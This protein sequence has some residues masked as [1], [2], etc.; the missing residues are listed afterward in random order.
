MGVA[1]WAGPIDDGWGWVRVDDPAHPDAIARS[2]TGAVLR[3]PPAEGPWRPESIPSID[4]VAL[5]G[6]VAAEAIEVTGA[7]SWHDAGRRGAG[8]RVAV[9]DL[10]WFVGDSVPGDVGAFE[11]RDCFVSTTCEASFDVERPSL[12]GEQGAHGWACAEVIRD[13]APDA[14][15]VLV[16]VNSFTALENAVDWAIRDGVDL[17][18]LSMSY[19]NDSFYDGRG[20]HAPLMTALERAGV[21]LVTSAGNNAAQHVAFT[22]DDADGDGLD[23]GDGDGGRWVEWARGAEA[24]VYVNWDQHEA[25]GRTDLG[26]RLV[27]ERGWIVAEADRPQEA[28]DPECAPVERLR[29]TLAEGGRLRVE[30]FAARGPTS[31]LRVDLLTRQGDLEVPDPH[32]SVTDPAAHPF[33]LAVGAARA[34]AYAEGVPQPYSAWGPSHGGA[35]KPDLVG[36]DGLSTATFGPVGFYGTSASTP[37]VVGL[38]ALVK[39]DD[40]SLSPAELRAFMRASAR[41]VEP[42]SGPDPAVG[43]GLARLPRVDPGPVRCGERPLLLPFLLFGMPWWRAG[44]RRG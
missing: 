41:R 29:A 30:V 18:S 20:P 38:L 21:T 31:D 32:S 42:G 13:L 6:G 12:T 22:F 28:G 26:V 23:D 40:P 5:S 1:A 24:V 15:I 10:G 39:G 4:Q 27:D 43:A 16:R 44:R 35:D 8:V 3:S 36:P 11:T 34:A 17:I 9:F 2:A 37:V 19:Y 25:C 14:E 7:R 33:A